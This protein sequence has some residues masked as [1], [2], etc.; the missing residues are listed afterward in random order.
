MKHRQLGEQRLALLE[1]EP[2]LAR[3]IRIVHEQP[4][5]GGDGLDQAHLLR[6]ERTPTGP[7]DEEHAAHRLAARQGGSEEHRV[8]AEGLEGLLVD[9][10]IVLHVPGPYGAPLAPHL[11]EHGQAVEHER[12]RPEVFQQRLGHVPARGRQERILVARQRVDA[13]HVGSERAADLRGH[14]A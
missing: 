3:E 5:L 13:D 1:T 14:A 9:A 4:D 10:R 11:S 12:A 8:R 7:P 2:R 6:R